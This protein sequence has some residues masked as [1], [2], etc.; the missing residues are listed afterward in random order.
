MSDFEKS[1]GGYIFY[2][3]ILYYKLSY[4][5]YIGKRRQDKE[6]TFNLNYFTLK[7]LC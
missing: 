7:D 4:S 5:L 2:I 6:I 3:A 1:Y